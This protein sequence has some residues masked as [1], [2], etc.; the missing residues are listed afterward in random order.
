MS[1]FSTRDRTAVM[2]G[3]AVRLAVQSLTGQPVTMTSSAE[4]GPSRRWF[5]PPIELKKRSTWRSHYPPACTKSSCKPR[6]ASGPFAGPA[7]PNTGRHYLPVRMHNQI[8]A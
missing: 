3:A 1:S 7:N 8:Q 2:G 6:T 5:R 4:G